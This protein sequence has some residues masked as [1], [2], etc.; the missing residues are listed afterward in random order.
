M[1]VYVYIVKS[2]AAVLVAGA[3]VESSLYPTTGVD[4]EGVLP[5]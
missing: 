2:S 3:K 1:M 4:E 5:D